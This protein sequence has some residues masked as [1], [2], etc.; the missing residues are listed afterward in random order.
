MELIQ[1]LGKWKYNDEYQ[2]SQINAIHSTKCLEWIPYENF[3][4]IVNI[5]KE[6]SSKI[7]LTDWSKKNIFYSWSTENKEWRRYSN[8]GVTLYEKYDHLFTRK[9]LACDK[10]FIDDLRSA[11]STQTELFKSLLTWA[12]S[13]V[14]YNKENPF[15]NPLSLDFFHR[16]RLT[17]NEEDLNFYDKFIW[18]MNLYKNNI[19]DVNSYNDLIPVSEL[20]FSKSSSIN[21]K[22]LGASNFKV[23]LSFEN[24]AGYA[25]LIRWINKNYL[26][27]V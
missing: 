9:V 21:E 3:Q 18:M 13:L 8:N 11:T 2:N 24:W 1:K 23:K 12:Y 27:K 5:N 20:R 25:N 14:K 7:Y 16:I 26:S 15:A 6:N 4:T 22:Q 19:I 17:L 10:L